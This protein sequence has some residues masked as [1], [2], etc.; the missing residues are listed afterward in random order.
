M[1]VLAFSATPRRG[2]NSDI[3][4]DHILEGVRAAGASFE[5]VRLAELDIAPCN[6]CAACQ[7]AVETP[8]VIGDDMAPLIDKMRVADGFV[9]GSPI[10]F[11]TVS[12]QMKLLL[13]RSYALFGADH[14]DVLQGR[15][16]ALAFSYGDTDPLSSGVVNALQTFQGAARFLGM[17]ICGW[18]H[19]SCNAAGE[20]RGNP[21]VLKT[22]VALGESL[23]RRDE[24]TT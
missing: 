17:E 9:F 1:H 6:A 10:Y 2:G 11:F 23:C 5:K 18:V 13:D 4:V 24:E 22:A 15:R 12:A 21:Q 19:A 16:M 3:L 8:C 20:V 14:F 7:D